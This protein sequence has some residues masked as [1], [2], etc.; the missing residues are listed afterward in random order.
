[1]KPILEIAKYILQENQ[2]E[3]QPSINNL[4]LSYINSLMPIIVLIIIG[5][6]L[7][8]IVDRISQD[9]VIK[10]FK[11]NWVV[12]FYED[13]DK[14][15]LNEA[16]LGK[17]R[18]PPRSEGAFEIDYSIKA[19]EN[20]IKLVAYLK[21]A[22]RTTGKKKYLD[23]AKEIYERL[24]NE[25]KIKIDFDDI[26]YDPFSEPTEASKKVY[27]NNLKD[28]YAIVR[29]ED[30]L[31]EK[32]LR[33]KRR[34]LEK[35]FHP[36][37]LRRFKRSVSNFL[38]LVK[39]KLKAAFGVI[40]STLTKIAP[41]T[42]DI[43]KEVQKYGEAAL[44]KV[45]SYEALLENSIGKLVKVQVNDIDKT[46]RYYNG[47]LREYSPNFIAVYNVDFPIDE[48]AVFIGNKLLEEFPRERLDFHG[49]E[50]NE[51]QHIE[52]I[53]YKYENGKLTFDIKN[54]HKDHIFVEKIIVGDK[55]LTLEDP[56]FTPN[57][58]EHVEINEVKE[59]PPTIRILYKIIK[60]ADVIWP[61]TKAKVIGA[62][63]PSETLV[64]SLL[65]R[66]DIIRH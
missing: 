33:E 40:T 30:F 1:M 61:N 48:E 17:I 34:E 64:E 38:S 28:I 27:K 35:I 7:G 22:Y 59:N 66:I 11:D 45:G 4:I 49:W 21:R 55:E 8:L 31:T 54:I 44:G 63:E 42:P 39:D 65:R 47:V 19:I 20:P 3:A 29:F 6:I 43:T 52:I 25:G 12:L 41:I 51:P 46:V 57:E 37:L 9:R 60:V 23:R 16:Y 36:G 24:V 50:L 14:N 53:N 18:I 2:P 10:L 62:G 32:E 56:N 26:K 13:I 58:I 5:V 15:G